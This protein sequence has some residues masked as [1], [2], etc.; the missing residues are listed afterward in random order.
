VARGPLTPDEI[1]LA[2]TVYGRTGSYQAAADAVGSDRSNVRRRLI[3]RGEPQRATLHAHACARGLRK[4]RSHV[5]RTLDLVARVL[6]EETG[7]GVSLE[8]KD[9]AALANTMARLSET[10]VSVS[11]R[12]DRRRGARLTREKTRAEIV[13]LAKN[14]SDKPTGP[15][16][17]VVRIED[18]DGA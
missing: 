11:D 4:A 17:V 15:V 9:L 10:L 1:E 13:A 6:N 5:A 8:P 18:D 3:A 14:G 16:T 7:A 2:A 12:E